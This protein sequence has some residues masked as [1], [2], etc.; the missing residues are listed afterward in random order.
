M[1][2]IILLMIVFVAV[3]VLGF[4]CGWKFTQPTQQM[5][6]VVN[7]DV[8]LTS[9]QNRGFLVTQ[10]YIFTEPVTIENTTGS[11]WKDLL[12]GQT[13]EARG[14][15]EVNLGVDLQKLT[16]KD[17]KIEGLKVIVNLPP[18]TIFN[19]RLVGPIEVSNKQG[20]IK[21]LF[22]ND[23]GYNQALE[24]LNRQARAA[25]TKEDLLKLADEKSKIEVARILQ[26]VVED[27]EIE[28]NIIN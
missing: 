19:T 3:F 25:A 23:D 11:V 24:E 7:A 15:M 14:V 28:V 22:N 5:T 20:I 17:I 1:K 8:I 18:S 9:L 13:I 12:L 10:T 26:L 27:K 6:K 4:I 16:A 2:K 21:R